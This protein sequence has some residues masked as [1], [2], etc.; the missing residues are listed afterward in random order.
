MVGARGKGEWI[1]AWV[2]GGGCSSTR[3]WV[4]TR[5]G[6]TGMRVCVCVCVR[7]FNQIVKCAEDN[8]VLSSREG[9]YICVKYCSQMYNIGSSR[10]IY[11]STKT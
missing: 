9:K 1:G 8:T 10:Y 5:G 2:A 4:L 7:V 11:R 3:S 6:L